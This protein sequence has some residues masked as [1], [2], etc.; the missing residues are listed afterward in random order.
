MSRYINLDKA[1]IEWDKIQRIYSEAHKPINYTDLENILYNADVYDVDRVVE[2]LKNIKVD[3][4]CQTCTNIKLC[5]DLQDKYN[6][7]DRVCLC[8]LVARE[9]AIEIVKGGSDD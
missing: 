6:P 7:N 2:Q 4:S 5:N 3:N 8:T 1:L 9:Q